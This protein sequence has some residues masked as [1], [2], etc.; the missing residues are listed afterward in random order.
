M[1]A[2]AAAPADDWR[3][4]VTQSYRNSEVR[5]IAKILASIDGQATPA[6]KMMLSM[7]FE[8]Q[9][10]KSASSLEDYKKKIAKRLKKLQKAYAQQKPNTP[11]GT[12]TTS[13][14]GGGGASSTSADEDKRQEVLLKLKQT[15]GEK[16]LYAIRNG[17]KA[18]KDI[19]RKLGAEKAE[20]LKPHIQSCK[21]WAKQMGIWDED[22]ESSSDKKT[23][24]PFVN[25]SLP[26][27]QRLEQYLE[28]RAESVRGYVAKHADPDLF[29]FET[30]ERKDKDVVGNRG[31]SKLLS[32]T[33]ARRIQYVQKQQQQ[34]QTQPSG[35]SN[36][37]SAASSSS[38]T[39]QHKPGD[40]QAIAATLK[41]LQQALEKA[42]ASVPPPTR[43]DS[44]QLEASLRHL[45]KIRAASTALM[46]YF[47]IRG[48]RI[49]TTAP[50]QTLKKI[51]SVMADSIEF[52]VN[53]LQERKS[54]KNGGDVEN[55]VTLQ[56]AW[57]KRMELP[58][59]I[60][61]TTTD[62]NDDDA[63]DSAPPPKR[64]RTTISNNHYKPY[65]KAR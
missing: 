10:Y 36:E 29:L 44:R 13:S 15:Y 11:T 14:G 49:T 1:S 5:E 43:N 45:D 16:I 60:M 33:L 50:P 47:T 17:D 28:K 54:S 39:A 32:T 31:A 25:P 9:I 65:Y 4:S 3:S 35:G 7:K 57:A 38:E 18:L 34:S 20:Q 61:S 51:Q 56:D 37:S 58:K 21:E 24:T 48:D 62:D 12:D 55:A 6:S 8:D 42:Q 64:A 53:V 19:E 41:E 26:D 22:E 40:D 23:K 63:T 27:L 52:V 59:P 2:L 30:L 46:N